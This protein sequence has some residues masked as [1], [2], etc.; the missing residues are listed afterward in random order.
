MPAKGKGKITPEQRGK[1]ARGKLSGKT[2]SQIAAETGLADRTVR[3]QATDPRT[4]TLIQ[5]LK[6]EQDKPLR[7]AFARSVETIEEHLEHEDPAV[8]RDA[9]RDLVR[10][11]E[12]GDPPL[13]RLELPRDNSRGDFTLVELLAV[14]KQLSEESA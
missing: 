5:E 8:V 1:I 14:Y 6:Q 13:A 11:V 4:L 2:S 7:R 9:R 10:I 3:R 12:A